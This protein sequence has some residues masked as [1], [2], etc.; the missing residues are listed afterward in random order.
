LLLHGHRVSLDKLSEFEGQYWGSDLLLLH[1]EP[2]ELPQ[3]P[4]R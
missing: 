2:W 3:T 1:G 4:W